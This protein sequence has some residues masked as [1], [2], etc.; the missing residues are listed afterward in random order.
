MKRILLAAFAVLIFCIQSAT[1]QNLV[2]NPSFENTSSNCANFAGE[3]YTTDLLNWDDANSG[4]DS[5]SSPDLFSACN[6]LPIPGFGSPTAMPSNILGYQYSHTGTHHV[7]IITHSPGNNYREYI[8]GKTSTPLVA[9]QSY[10]V[11]MYVSLANTMPFATNNLGIRLSSTNYQRDACTNNYNNVINQTPQL[12]YGCSPIVDTSADW[13]RLQWNYVA[14]GGEQYFVIGNFFP[15]SGTTVVNT[16]YPGGSQ[17]YAYYFIDDVSI[18]P[19]N[20]CDADIQKAGPF[21]VTDAPVTLSVL[22]PVDVVTCTRPPVTG[23]WSGPGIT[24]TALGTFSPAV[25]GVGVHTVTYTL[26]CGKAVTRQISVSTCQPITVC[27]ETNGNFT[28]SGGVTGAYKWQRQV[29]VQDCN[30]CVPALPPF[31]AA[32][33]FPAGCA[34]MVLVWR[35]FATGTTVT[36]PGTFPLRVLDTTGRELIITAAGNVPSCNPCPTI[37]VNNPTKQNVTCPSTNNGSATVAASGGATPYTYA[38]SGG[39]G[40]GATKSNLSAGTYT[41]TATDANLCTGT[42]TVTITAPA[43]PTLTFSGKVEPGCSQANGSVS[44]TFASGTAPYQVNV[45]N[46]STSTNQTVPIATTVPISNLAAGTYTISV[47][48][49]GGCTTV[50]TI[51]FTEPTPPVISSVTSTPPSCL[52]ASDGTATVVATGGTGTLTYVWSNTQTTSTITGLAAGNFI[53]TVSD[54]SGCKDTGN[55]T[56]AAGPAC[57]TLNLS[58]SAT[59]PTCGQSNGSISISATPAATYSYTWSGGLPATATQSNLP[60]GQYFVTVSN[61]AISGCTKDTSIVL[62][63]P[64]GPSLSFAGKVEPGCGQ[65]N[66]SINATLSGGTAPYQVTVDNGSTPTTQTFPIAGTAPLGN[67]PA[68]TYIITVVDASS[69]STTQTIVFTEPAGPVITSVTST[70]TTCA[71]GSDGTATVVASGGTGALTYV[72]SNTQTTTTISTLTAGNYIVT[73]TDAAGCKDT[74]NVAVADGPVCCTLNLS[75]SATQPACGQSNGSISIS[76]TPAATYS[77]TWSGG[78]PATA[79]QSNLPSGQYFVTVSN[80]S[81]S[82]CTKDTSIVL[83]NPNG[84]ALSFAGKVEPGCGQANGE[85]DATL[86]GGTAPYQVTVDNGSTP[87]TQALPFAGTLP[88]K[89]LPAGTYIITVVDASS[90]ST[91]QT[92]VFTEPAGPAITSITSTPTTCQGGADGTATALASGGTG[93]LS[94]LWSNSQTSTNIIGITAGNFVVTVTDAAGC[95]DTGNVAVADGPVCCNIG[96]SAALTQPGCGLSDGSIVPAITGSGNYTFAWS[97]SANTKDITNVAAGNYTLT[98]TDVTQGCSKD[99]AFSLSNP[100]APVISSIAVTPVPCGATNDGTI[101]VQ[102]SSANGANPNTAYTWSNSSTE[103]SNTQTGLVAGTYSFTITDALGCKASGSGTITAATNCCG[104]DISATSTGPDCGQNNATIDVVMNAAGTTPYSYSIDG[105]VYQPGTTFSNLAAGT[106]SVYVSDATGCGDTTTITIAAINNTLVLNLQNTDPG[107]SGV[108]DGTVTAIVSGG[109]GAASFNWSNNA[110]NI[111]AQSNLA[112]GTYSVTVSDAAGCSQ[113][114]SA[115]LNAA[116]AVV[117][118]LNDTVICV[119]DNFV[120]TAPAGFA[121]YTWSGGETTQGIRIDSTNTYSVTVSDANGCSATDAALVRVVPTPI[122]TMTADTTIFENNEVKLSPS[123]TGNT[124]G[125]KYIWQSDRNLSCND[126]ASPVASPDDTI[127]YLLSYTSVEGCR[128]SASITVNIESGT[129]LFVPNLFSPNGDGDND[130]LRIFA[131][132]LK[133]MNWKVFNRWGEKVFQ[134]TDINVGW[135][136]N[137]NGLMQPPGVYVYVVELTFLN[138]KKRMYTGGLTLVR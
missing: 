48:D 89:N 79:T 100:T 14:T 126:C 43:S 29:S 78:L 135:D 19:N 65:A 124:A 92:I 76:A 131:I 2:V 16:G 40:T 84:P 107:C 86:S 88:L 91:T 5:C 8:Q 70:P 96:I 132:G 33:S 99:S 138:K 73:V 114:A 137:Y 55:V 71:G 64:N 121:S 10:C 80:T 28:A 113:T 120:L 129:N 127:T 104:V 77:Y 75:A 45:N 93:A 39:A 51:T 58:A 34:K 83:T 42:T 20:C 117:V 22:A 87:T 15:T 130:I 82:G 23:I 31:V 69:C 18:V 11:S 4:A 116:Q 30:S 21:C 125:A 63:N 95:K 111:A 134:S 128:A 35:N 133:E 32:C 36:P 41:V 102:A 110:G 13:V 97:N 6:T 74:G 61:T 109:S 12:N 122:I 103:I 119:G 37:T 60:S 98:V 59:Q 27:R 44:A 112:A 46:G 85:V 106:Y 115:V 25:A 17:P 9:G 81:I 108:D 57:C 50:Q 53:V 68:G 72:W 1:A 54:A 66:G 47:T 52:G 101:I 123:I 3:G 105:T 118:N 38:W 56:V 62:T 49:G 90:C 94:Y 136:G 67:L 26:S 24:N 7:G